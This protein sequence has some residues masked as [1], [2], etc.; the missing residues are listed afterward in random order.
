MR[1]GAALACLGCL[2]TAA[3]AAGQSAPAGASGQWTGS[4]QPPTGEIQ[5]VVNL[6]GKPGEPWKGA[7]DIPAQGAKGL[8]LW[9]I[10]VKDTAVSFAI[11][12]VPG[13]PRFTGKLSAD[14]K[15]MS[16]DFSQ[17]GGTIPFSLVR[18]GDAVFEVP[19]KSTPI[20]KEL[21][22]SWEG[23]L[24]T[25]QAQLRLVLKLAS[26]AGGASGV[27][28]SVDQGGVEIPVATIT[29]DGS[30]VKLIV[31]RVGG[32]YEGAL[33]GDQMTGTWTQGGKP[34]PLTFTRSK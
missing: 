13:E 22:G 33:K 30:T 21:E 9:A 3:T 24:D 17:G 31:T 16:G 18:K 20:T 26:Q 1:R 8:P 10:T 11:E 2:L 7:I 14:G 15:S 32:T 29:Q 6:A 23:T 4:L 25:G 28:V 34:L 5:I 19:A 12:G 27:L